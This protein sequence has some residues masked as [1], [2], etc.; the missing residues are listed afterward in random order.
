MAP[1]R[2][3]FCKRSHS[4]RVAHDARPFRGFQIEPQGHWSKRPRCL[5]ILDAGSG[6]SPDRA[7]ITRR[8]AGLR[9]WTAF[10]KHHWCGDCPSVTGALRRLYRCRD[11]RIQRIRTRYSSLLRDSSG[12]RSADALRRDGRRSA[13]RWTRNDPQPPEFA[14]EHRRCADRSAGSERIARIGF[15]YRWYSQKGI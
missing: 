4:T 6:L 14:S 13:G 15:R 1:R 7:T 10:G 11:G 12:S 8:L 2:G 5:R 9:D 3:P